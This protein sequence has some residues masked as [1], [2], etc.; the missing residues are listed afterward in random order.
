MNHGTISRWCR[1][2]QVRGV[3]CQHD[4]DGGRARRIVGIR[5]TRSKERGRRW[6]SIS[7]PAATAGGRVIF[8]HTQLTEP[9]GA[10]RR[11]VLK[12]TRWRGPRSDNRSPTYFKIKKNGSASG[13]TSSPGRRCCG[14]ANI[15]SAVTAKG[16]AG[17]SIAD[18]QVDGAARLRMPVPSR[19]HHGDRRQAPHLWARNSESR[20]RHLRGA[21]EMHF[22]IPT[23]S[24]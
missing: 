4:A 2:H 3:E 15:S 17:R 22:F 8:T 10:A 18:W 7:A 11:G 9:Y 21:A 1:R 16:R 14:R 23:T 6:R 13:K 20:W 5:L 12:R 24:G 19:S